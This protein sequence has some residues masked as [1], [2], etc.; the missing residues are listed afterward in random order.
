MKALKTVALCAVA[1]G[2]A[3]GLVSYMA[4]TV[5]FTSE[6]VIGTTMFGALISL[7]LIPD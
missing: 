3:F 5:A 7:A 6:H 4:G 1:F 2:L